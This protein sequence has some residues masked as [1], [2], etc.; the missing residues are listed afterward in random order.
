M[1]KHNRPII[2][3]DT[4]NNIPEEY[5][6][7]AARPVKSMDTEASSKRNELPL[8]VLTSEVAAETEG[9]YDYIRETGGNDQYY[10]YE[11][12]YF[13]PSNQKTE[14]LSQFKKLRMLSVAHK[15]LE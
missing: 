4:L 13:L 6:I 1:G 9:T 15:D 8:C 11:S 7:P 2:D 12:P 3:N 5:L 10:N 14:L